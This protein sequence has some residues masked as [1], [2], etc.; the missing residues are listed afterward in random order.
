[1][2]EAAAAIEGA[3]GRQAGGCAGARACLRPRAWPLQWDGIRC[4]RTT[5]L[6]ANC[7]FNLSPSFSLFLFVQAAMHLELERGGLL[8]IVSRPLPLLASPLDLSS[9]P[10]LLMKW[11]DR[12]GR[13]GPTVDERALIYNRC[14]DWSLALDSLCARGPR[15]RW[16]G[17][18][19][20]VCLDCQL[21]VAT[22]HSPL[23][24]RYIIY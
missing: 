19:A 18:D 15:Q 12:A 11:H 13:G 23:A 4:R 7:F 6:L 16:D 24:S 22:R 8:L 5:A 9:W 1:M 10:G 14:L 2:Q 3:A 17:R 21:P 20:R